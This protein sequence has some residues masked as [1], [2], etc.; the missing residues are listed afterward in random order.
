MTKKQ[1]RK[2]RTTSRWF[3]IRPADDSSV[4]NSI[5]WG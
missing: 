2:R 4:Q 3:S 1:N 5:H